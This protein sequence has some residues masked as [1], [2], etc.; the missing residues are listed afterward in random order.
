MRRAV[1]LTLLLAGAG[2]AAPVAAAV[3]APAAPGR[4]GGSV[5]FRSGTEGYHTFRI[6]AVVQTGRVLVAFAEG[7]RGSAGDSGDIDVVARRSTDGGCNWGPLQ[8]VTDAGPDTAGNPAPV[9]DPRTGRITLL[10]CQNAGSVTER[11]I[12]TGQLRPEQ[13]R[14]VFVQHSADAG[15]S[16][17][18]RRE[19]TAAVKPAGWRWYA[20]GPGHAIA[21]RHGRYAGRLLVPANHSA[22][23]PT[24]SPDTGAEDRYYG[25]HALY[26]DD[27]GRTWRIGFVDSD[28]DGRVNPNESTA[29]QLPDGRLYLNTRDQHGT[30][31]GSRADS[32]SHDGGRTLERPYTAHPEL[33]GPVVQGS[34]LRPAGARSPLLYSGPA[35]PGRRAA[36][37][38]RASW[39]GGVSWRAVRQVSTAP[40]AYSDLVELVELDSR[41]VGLLYETG[42]RG[43]YEDIAFTRLP[44]AEL[45]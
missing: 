10:T 6:P 41:L 21:L 25:G 35:D 22:A 37:T 33:T 17:S 36:M 8:L 13:G 16:W 2:A 23:P 14:R 38:V 45:D 11:Q 40:A 30:A 4:C 28:G 7:R 12:R 5:P 27:A 26:S 15:R 18:P 43:P 1:L 20:T 3:A 24:G 29:A 39:D 34:V 44:L 42:Q 19:I 31:P 32:Y 9:V